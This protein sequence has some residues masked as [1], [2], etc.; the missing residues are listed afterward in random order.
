M[1]DKKKFVIK[2]ILWIIFSCVAPISF[3]I[4]RFDLFQQ[5]SSIK[6]GGW[7]LL[8]ILILFV[9]LKVLINNL[10]KSLDYSF[11]KQV[12]NG[13]VKVT[14]PLGLITL[15]LFS[16]RNNIEEAFQFFAFLTI[17][18]TIGTIISPFPK[19]IDNKEE[20]NM[21][22]LKDYVSSVLGINRDKK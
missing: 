9:F 8:V 15:A 21:I 1:N 2:L 10:D 5:V 14:L 7:G 4:Y 11:S 12:L 3:L 20:N 6:I 17:S 18:E 16:I 13:I 19:L 22:K